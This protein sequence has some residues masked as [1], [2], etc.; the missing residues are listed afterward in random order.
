MNLK[1][2]FTPVLVGTLLSSHQG[3]QAEMEDSY[4]SLIMA[5]AIPKTAQEQSLKA[6]VENADFIF[7]GV[8]T[9]IEYRVSDNQPQLPHS[10]VT[11]KVEKLLKGKS[12]QQSITLRFVGG[13]D[14]EGNFLTV[15]GVP[16]FDI[17]DRD[18]LFVKGNG[19]SGCPLVEC[20]A[21]RLRIINQQVF[22]ADGRAIL[23]KSQAELAYGQPLALEEVTTNKIGNT[24]IRDVSSTAGN[25]QDSSGGDVV[26][27]QPA[28]ASL[29]SLKPSQLELLIRNQVQQTST[30]LNVQA[31]QFNVSVDSRSRFSVAQP[32][33]LSPPSQVATPLTSPASKP[34][35]EAERR[36]IE[37]LEQNSGNPV[38]PNSKP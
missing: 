28:L 7:Q 29:P 35:T 30:S 5:Q 12:N 19:K 36:E 8:V 16:L 10:F 9:K 34:Q 23:Q 1:L 4:K 21:G 3:V 25:S 33:P 13:P 22:T 15:S 11:F 6:P 31:Q 26:E 2:I 14:G 27:S 32:Q 18:V 37:M 17:G 20:S 38:F 24:V